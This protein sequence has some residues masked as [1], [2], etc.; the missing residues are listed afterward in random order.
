MSPHPSEIPEP[1]LP[2]TLVPFPTDPHPP[3]LALTGGVSRDGAQLAI[4]YRLTGA[5]PRLVLP[6]PATRPER[7]DDLWRTTCL[8]CFLAIPE[9]SAYWELNLSPAGHWNAYRLEAY[10]EGLAP[11]PAF[12][13]P[14]LELQS[15][16]GMLELLLR[17]TLPAALAQAPELLL[18]VTAVIATAEGELSH[19]AL[20][21][22]GA[23]ADFHRRDGFRLRV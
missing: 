18:A 2:F 22:P 8:E 9:D 19:W 10:R 1:G 6:P 11:D 4:R 15:G 7:R 12:D 17:C 14:R 5:L 3:G 13:R 21:H 16:S 20:L 23:A